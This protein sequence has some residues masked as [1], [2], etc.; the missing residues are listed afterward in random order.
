[1]SFCSTKIFQTRL[2]AAIRDISEC[3]CNFNRPERD[4][5]A[6]VVNIMEQRFGVYATR[7]ILSG[8]DVSDIIVACCEELNAVAESKSK[9]NSSRGPGI[10]RKVRASG[11]PV[12]LTGIK[13]NS[14]YSKCRRMSNYLKDNKSSTL[15]CVPIVYN[16]CCIGTLSS[17]FDDNPAS[18][19]SIEQNTLSIIAG[20]IANVV[21]SKRELILEKQRLANE[22]ISLRSLLEQQSGKPIIIGNSPAVKQVLDKVRQV[23]GYDTNVLLLGESGTGK[24][25]IAEAIH[26]QSVRAGKPLIK[27][28]CSAITTT[29]FESE[30]F[31]HVKGAFTGAE[32]DRSGYIAKAEGGTLFFDEIGDFSSVI[33]V[34]LLRF[35]QERQYQKVGSNELIDADVRFIFATN[36]DMEDLVKS[37]KFRED[38]WYRIS[39]FC[40]SIPPLRQRVEDI[41]P[42]ANYYLAKYSKTSAKNINGFSSQSVDK[43][44]SHQWSGNIRE[45]QNW[46]EYAVLTCRGSVIESINLPDG[47]Q[48]NIGLEDISMTLKDRLRLLEQDIVI[49][50]I[51]AHDYHIES[52]AKTLGISAR[53][54]NYKIKDW[55]I[56]IPR[57]RNPRQNN[58]D[59]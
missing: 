36:L 14:V 28:N 44:L 31:G 24:E 22:N 56:S 27:I 11:E 17:M 7:I 20:L 58:K 34:K 40:I 46:V 9:K 52:A 23:A 49:N 41:L 51:T 53:M 12:I 30:L 55:K 50:S 39:G 21:S 47:R 57:K 19:F 37:G 8:E 13:T 4:V 26:S 38:L 54:L 6:D 15:V 2:F 42:L 45:L 1:M 32:I 5:L 33:Q 16:G 48:K 43:L 25:L 3:I 10:S 59:A 18:D 35:F 29:L